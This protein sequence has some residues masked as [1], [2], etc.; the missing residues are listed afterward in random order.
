[1]KNKKVTYADI[2]AYTGFSKSTISRYFNSPDSLPVESQ[3]K[4]AQ[5][6][7][8]LGYKENK[9][10]RIL[11]NGKTELVGVLVPSLCMH[12]YWEMLGCL[13]DTCAAYGY[14]FLVFTG[15][16][17]RDR[18]QKYLEELLAYNIEGM[19]LLSPTIPSRQLAAYN[20]PM[21]AIEREDQCICSVRTDNYLGGVQATSLLKKSG[22]DL[23]VHVNEDLPQEV[24]AY[25][26]IQGFLDTCQEQ[27]L[28]HQLVLEDPGATCQGN[29]ER[30]TALVDM[31]E[32][33]Y[34]DKK[35]GI[36]MP[37]DTHANVLLNILVRRHG[38]LPDT[39][40]IVGFDN[41]PVSQQAVIPIS[42]VDRQ[43]PL[44]AA[45]AMRLLVMQMDEG[46]KRRPAPLTEPVHKVIPPVVVR[47]ET[48]D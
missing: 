21:V 41:S 27:F 25:W 38:G 48:T 44:M 18:E 16:D 36:F 43:I 5:A 8:E 26:K 42:T 7:E 32:E 17:D 46:K 22:C 11:A 19:I 13:L 24:P 40:R 29:P 47:R 35:K 14:K 34:P 31:L 20:L 15:K 9:I 30:L 12:Y 33:K 10:A 23:L 28:A 45:E 3:E 1:M 4:I 6:L 39:W 2:A 37:N